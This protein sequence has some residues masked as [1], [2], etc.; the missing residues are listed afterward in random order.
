[1]SRYQ[2]FLPL[3]LLLTA[4]ATTVTPVPFEADNFSS[5]LER[6]QFT[7]AR[8]M[9]AGPAGSTL[10]AQVHSELEQQLDT[11]AA[12]YA[13]DL[14]EEARGL[15]EQEQW[16]RAGELFSQGRDALPENLQIH[17]AYMTFTDERARYVSDVKYQ[18]KLHRAKMLPRQ[19]EL[20]RLL[21]V[22]D[23]R[24]ERLQNKLYDME[25]EAESLVLFLTPIAQDAYAAGNYQESLV[26]DRQILELG[27]SAQS[28]QRIAAIE[29]KQAQ[30]AQRKARDRKQA[31]KRKREALLTSYEVAVQGGEFE[32]ARELLEQLSGLGFSGSEADAE[33]TR[34]N[35]LIGQ[36]SEA[37]ISEGKK[38]Y[39]RGKLDDAIS[40]WRQALQLT[41]D[42]QDLL[43]RIK[44]AETFQANYQRLTR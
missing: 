36:R 8:A 15:R 23:P 4:C 31:V 12:L 24:D 5:L 25:Q 38:H 19:I 28:R 43:G 44:R 10:S 26:Y 27:E 30:V 13:Q 37:L 6:R 16:H 41:P 20:T 33:F 34:L 32:Q 29:A 1:M 18:M 35:S 39:T 40:S 42:N 14:I 2:L 17:A 9:L 11:A 21:G 3:L 22:V 7:Q